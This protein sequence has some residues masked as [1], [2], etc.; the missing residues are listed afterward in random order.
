MYQV[1]SET[2]NANTYSFVRRARSFDLKHGNFQ[3]NELCFACYILLF[4]F[5][6]SLQTQKK[7]Q[8]NKSE[9]DFLREM[10]FRLYD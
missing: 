2:T 6:S 5:A 9:R 8:Q 1:A 10:L 3:S 4:P 7:Q